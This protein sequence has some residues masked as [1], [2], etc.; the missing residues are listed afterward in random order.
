MILTNHSDQFNVIF[1]ADLSQDLKLA[2]VLA[3][4]LFLLRLNVL[5]DNLLVELRLINVVKCAHSSLFKACVAQF[6]QRRLHQ[7][8]ILSLLRLLFVSLSVF[9]SFF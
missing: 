8:D 4:L 7:N 1:S 9:H 5:I 3:T 6:Q 2:F